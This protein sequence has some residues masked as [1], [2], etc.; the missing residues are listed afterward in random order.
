MA[1]LMNKVFIKFC[2]ELGKTVKETCEML[3]QASEESTMGCTQMFE[4]HSCFKNGWTS[5]DDGKHSGQP[6][7]STM[8]ENV[9]KVWHAIR[10]DRHHTINN[11]CDIVG[12]GYGTCQWILT[13]EL[14]MWRLQTC[15]EAPVW[16]PEAASTSRLSGAQR[17]CKNWPQ[18]PF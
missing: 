11:I 6:S 7:S 12:I 2:Q 14:H 3:K 1:D 8:P 18:L 16:G 9:E 15:A 13:E 4:W 5:V 10:E 17:S